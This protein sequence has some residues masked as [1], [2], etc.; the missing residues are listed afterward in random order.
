MLLLAIL[1]AAI[2]LN[3]IGLPG[4]LKEPLL[5]ELRERGWNVEFT[6]MRWRWFKGI[7]IENP[8]FSPVDP[9]SHSKFS[10]SR[11]EVNMDFSYKKKSKVVLK[12][13]FI[14]EGEFSTFIET[15][16]PPLVV[17]NIEARVHL[18][19]GDRL[20]IEPFEAQ[21]RDVK[22]LLSCD[23]TNFSELRE[24]SFLLPEKQ[25]ADA[26]QTAVKKWFELIQE[27]KFADEP[28]VTL[29]VAGDLRDWQRMTAELKVGTA[30]ATT[31][32][33]RF[34]EVGFHGKMNPR[35]TT[36]TPVFGFE[37]GSAN[38]RTPWGNMKSFQNRAQFS[39][40]SLHT[41]VLECEFELSAET[42]RTRWMSGSATNLLRSNKAQ[43]SGTTALSLTNFQLIE[44][45]TEVQLKHANLR[46][47]E[48]GSSNLLHA[49][50]HGAEFNVAYDPGSRHL[51]G[52]GEEFGWWTNLQPFTVSGRFD[53]GRLKDQRLNFD[54]LLVSG[55]WSWPRVE[56]M[57]VQGSLFGGQ[58][59]GRGNL[60]VVTR[61][62]N[63]KASSG[64]DIKKLSS[65]LPLQGRQ[66]LS[67]FAWEKAPLAQ[68]DIRLVLPAWTNAEPNW[69]EEV[70]PTLLLQAHMEVEKSSFRK[71]PVTSMSADLSYSNNVWRVPDVHWVSPGTDVKLSLLANDRSFDARVDGHIDPALFRS[72]LKPA[73]QEWFDRVSFAKAPKLSAF[74]RGD[75]GDLRSIGAEGNF[76]CDQ[77]VVRGQEFSSL[78]TK[79]IYTNLAA[80]FREVF[81][82][83]HDRELTADR[84]TLHTNRVYFE[85]VAS[86][87]DPML[88]ANIIG[89]DVIEV[90]SPY[91]FV[92]P[93]HV[94]LNGSIGLQTIKDA[95]MRFKIA[96][97]D[98]TWGYLQVDAGSGEANWINQTLTLT[99]LNALAYDGGILTGNA[100]LDFQ[101]SGK[102][103][104]RMDVAFTN[105]NVQTAVH[106]IGG[107]NQIEGRLNG[108]LTVNSADTTGLHTWN[109]YGR[110][111]LTDGLIWEMPIF[112]V[113]SPILDAIVPGFGKSRARSATADFI[114]TNGIAYSDDLEI[115]SSGFRMQY[116][117]ALSHEGQI[118]ARVV[119]EPLRDTWIVG[120]VLSSALMPLSKLFEYKVTG[121]AQNPQMKP[122]YVPKVVMMTLRPFK[123]LKGLLPNDENS[124]DSETVPVVER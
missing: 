53:F 39:L 118:D 16:T 114:I 38:L 123:T 110:G 87:I 2:Y 104:Y 90:L 14:R 50:L 101:V 69:Q 20:I 113:F 98:L 81:L 46:W 57:D 47:Q 11:A 61:E 18:L 74:V 119:A 54:K 120:R 111:E 25:P 40:S 71:I 122:V 115:K 68:A 85:N 96:G 92:T 26:S 9:A 102:A 13:I 21:F 17:Q 27:I 51:L 45:T 5:T 30:G 116:R 32:W 43:L 86:T 73:E 107:T 34:D 99:N 33:G 88:V 65:L 31:P 58:F 124:I 70:L 24:L 22:F 62:V 23:L 79:W 8:T 29:D 60:D 64:I 35:G 67:Q 10:A 1:V 121:P 7:V 59:S 76:S 19:P 75:L 91:K 55:D 41:N 82:K 56:V 83:R 36:N 95:D 37:L 72:Q 44:A 112:G 15:N 100:F 3:T 105:V 63:L 89:E 28:E 109:G 42:I 94:L 48:P 12:S 103:D 77:F 106:S 78:T 66:V 52:G 6:R 49:T 108:T 93:P 117:G 80:E 4:V 84:I 97:K